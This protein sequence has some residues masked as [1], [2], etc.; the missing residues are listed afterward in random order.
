MLRQDEAIEFLLSLVATG[1]SQ[2]S[3]AAV[4]ALRIYQDDRDLATRIEQQIRQRR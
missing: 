3:E 4:A 2:D 1:N